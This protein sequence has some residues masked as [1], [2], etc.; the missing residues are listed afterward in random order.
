MIT[1]CS[2]SKRSLSAPSLVDDQ[3]PP[4]GCC[5][6]KP[7]RSH[8]QVLGRER[9]LSELFAT[10]YMTLKMTPRL[11]ESEEELKSFFMKVKEESGKVGLKLNI[12]Q[13]KIMA[14]GPITSWEIDGE[15]VETV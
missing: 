7:L 10:D 3:A 9:L 13:T 11:W 8:G 5:C 4:A 2:E 14:F 6:P 1:G 12:Q 15:T